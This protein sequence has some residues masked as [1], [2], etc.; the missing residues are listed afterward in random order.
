MPHIAVKMFRG[1]TEEQK[2]ALAQKLEGAIVDVLGC[3]PAVVSI[4]IE[5]FDPAEWEEK[6]KK[7]D[8]E[9]KKD[10]LYKAPGR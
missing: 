6:V 2:K 1:R 9:G 4:T 8:I 10:V 7:S 3:P 5:D